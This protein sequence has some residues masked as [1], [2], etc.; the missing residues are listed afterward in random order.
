[1]SPRSYEL[2]PLEMEVMGLLKEG[3]AK[4]V[5]DIQDGLKKI[6]KDLA[7]TTVM[8]IL[9]RLHKKGYLKRKKSGRQY[10]YS[11]AESANRLGESV[12]STVGKALFR[13]QNLK[14]ILA[15]L[16]DNDDLSEKELRT[17]KKAVDQ[18]LNEKAKR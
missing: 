1:M 11:V 12:L 10:L 17:L 7:Y 14:P 9:V 16:D 6:K 15:L 5:S 4:S 13:N 8:T 3:T 2:G 18:K